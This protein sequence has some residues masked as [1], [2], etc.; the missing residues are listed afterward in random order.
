LLLVVDGLRFMACLFFGRSV[1][2]CH[3]E[4]AGLTHALAFV[5]D[6]D[7]PG[8]AF[9]LEAELDRNRVTGY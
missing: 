6:D 1:I 9:A 4:R 3:I 5:I 2:G 8:G 7:P